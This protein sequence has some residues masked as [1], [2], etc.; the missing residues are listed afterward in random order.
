MEQTPSQA[1][2]PGGGVQVTVNGHVIDSCFGTGTETEPARCA[3]KAQTVA[4]G[5]PHVCRVFGTGGVVFQCADP[6]PLAVPAP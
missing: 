1:W 4:P 3:D 5:L 2:R 6:P